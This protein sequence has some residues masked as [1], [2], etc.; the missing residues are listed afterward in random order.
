MSDKK[1]IVTVLLLPIDIEYLVAMTK[2]AEDVAKKRNQTL[3]CGYVDG[4]KIEIFARQAENK[5]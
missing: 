1:E 3:F 4:E 5:K 2:A